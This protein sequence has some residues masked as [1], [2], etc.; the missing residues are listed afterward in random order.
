MSFL[1]VFVD[2]KAFSLSFY[3]SHDDNTHKRGSNETIHTYTFVYI[4]T[5]GIL[6]TLYT[7]LY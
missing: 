7:A 4:S 2:P 3:V 6:D 1:I 5:T